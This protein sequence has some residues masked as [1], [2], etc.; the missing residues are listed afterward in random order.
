MLKTEQTLNSDIWKPVIYSISEDTLQDFGNKIQTVKLSQYII[1]FMK[2]F[3]RPF[4]V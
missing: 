3:L 4:Y 2:S 1:S